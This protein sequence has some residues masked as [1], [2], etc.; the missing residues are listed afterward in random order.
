MKQINF[1]TEETYGEDK[2]H[3]IIH[4]SWVGRVEGDDE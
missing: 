2:R 1:W 4:V 3:G